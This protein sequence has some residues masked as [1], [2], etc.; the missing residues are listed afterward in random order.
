MRRS[1][2]SGVGRVSR[3]FSVTRWFTN[4]FVVVVGVLALQGCSSKLGDGADLVGCGEGRLECAAGVCVEPLSDQANCGACGIAC[5]AGE[6]CEAGACATF[7]GAGQADCGAGCLSTLS[8]PGNCGG[9][10]L[11]CTAGQFCDLGACSD[12]CSGVRCPSA[13]GVELCAHLDVDAANCGQCG[14]VCGAG[15]EC[16]AGQCV[17]ACP[18]GRTLCGTECVD[19]ATAAAH[20]GVCGNACPS[21]VA[22]TEG[23]CGGACPAGGCACA[24]GQLDCGGVCID[25]TSNAFHCGACNTA[26]FSGQSCTATGCQCPDARTACG[27]TCVDTQVS[28]QHCGMCGQACSGGT[29]CQSGSCECPGTQT[30]CDDQ[31]VDTQLSAVHCGECGHVCQ[32]FEGCEAGVC[33]YSGPDGDDCGGAAVGI[34]ITRVALYQAV[35]A[36]LFEAGEPLEAEE[37]AVDVIQGRSAL[38]RVFVTPKSGFAARELSARIHLTTGGETT[39]VHHRRSVSAASTQ[40]SLDSTFRLQVPAAAIGADTTYYVELVECGG[41]ASGTAGV[42]RLPASGTA[43]LDARKTGVVKVA[44]VPILHDGLLPDTSATAL[45]LYA[46]AVMKE[47]PTVEVQTSVATQVNSGQT[48]VGVNLGN[49]LDVVR[50]KRSADG[51]A[52][53]VYYYGLVRPAATFNQYCQGGC[54]TGVAYVI[55][56]GGSSVSYRAGIGVG[57]ANQ[58]SAGTFVHELGHNHGREHA[59]CGVSGDANY[60]HSGGSIGTWG[61]DLV[62]ATLYNPANYTDFMGYCNPTWVSDYTYRALTER[63]VAVNGTASLE[64]LGPEATWHV[65]MVSPAG[66]SWGT[67]M[68]TRH[69]MPGPAER[70]VVYDAHGDPLT[71]VDVYRVELSEGAGYHLLVP[72][73]QRGW[74]AIGLA[75]GVALPY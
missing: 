61:Y 28:N 5:V 55:G 11:S 43:E 39:I 19:L 3:A 50:A 65:L 44:F 13:T 40:A 62:G 47:Y 34:D 52:A 7:C 59:P 22:C 66:P 69:G 41:T 8:D 58:T 57:Y 35:E 10:A 56:T 42:A 53:D 21:G 15:L 70:A 63:I 9:C 72:P 31:C 64:V 20:C 54:T 25:P 12:T 60:P 26:C 18:L 16:Q 74:Y 75:G 1:W 46:D 36:E 45:K 68:T 30:S 4:D 17:T 27:T 6:Y 73:R 67:P 48:G 33:L 23:S 49:M 32:D 37:R 71:E 38:V 24:A 51:P 29:T 14:V 2:L